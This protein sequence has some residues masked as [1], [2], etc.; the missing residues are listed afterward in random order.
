M[1][2]STKAKALQSADLERIQQKLRDGKELT[3]SERRVLEITAN[4]DGIKNKK[5]ADNIV[6]LAEILGVHRKT[7]Y[8]WK[9]L[10]GAP[11]AQD[12]GLHDVAAW[13][14]FVR[15]HEL[16]P[17]DAPSQDLNAIKARKLLAEAEIKEEQAAQIKGQTVTLDAVNRFMRR[18]VAGAVTL[19]R[20][21]FENELPPILSGL[22]ATGIR[23]ECATAI[24]EVCQMLSGEY[25]EPRGRKT[26]KPLV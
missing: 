1:K 6:E 13:R 3:A 7:I 5:F 22:D 12:N 11:K 10:D 26:R 14:A 19:L 9:K 15:A 25:D 21:K 20:N 4:A 24:D 23:K 8:E 2:E 17:G 18:K 16:G